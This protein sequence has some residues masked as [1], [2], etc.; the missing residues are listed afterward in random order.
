MKRKR[1][2]T[3]MAILLAVLV[4]GIGYA[5]VS[6]VTLNLSGTANISS[7]FDFDVKYDSSTAI[8]YSTT[9]TT[10]DSQQPAET[11]PVVTGQYSGDHDATMTVWLDKDHTEAYAVYKVK[12][13]SDKINAVLSTSVS[14]V[15]ETGKSEY[16]TEPT[17]E[18]FT[19]SAC[20]DALGSAELP[21]GQSAYLKVTIGL[22]KLPLND[23][24]G[25]TFSIT[26]TAEP[27]ETDLNPAP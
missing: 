3:V 6:S 4:L 21:H 11:H 7:N 24:T 5:A 1:T 20:T 9:D 14:P 26:T 15:G 8:S 18:Y 10:T 2:F 25:G 23:V 19:D 13:T 22:A 27:V 16:F 17:A 12:N